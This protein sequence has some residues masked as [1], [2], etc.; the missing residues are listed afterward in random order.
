MMAGIGVALGRDSRTFTGGLLVNAIAGVACQP[1]PGR[2]PQSRPLDI[3]GALLSTSALILAII[4]GPNW[5]SPRLLAVVLGLG[6][7]IRERHAPYPL[8]DFALFR[9]PRFSTG[10]ATISLAFFSGFIFGFTQYLQ[11]VQGYRLAAGIRFLPIAAGFMF[12]AKAMKQLRHHQS[13]GL[14]T[15]MTGMPLVLLWET[16]TSYLVVGPIVAVFALGVGFGAAK[17]GVGSAMN[18]VTQMLASALRPWSD[19]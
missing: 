12:G 17:A 19:Q 9:L 15:I 7:V 8:L 14:L 5:G 3:P 1:I 16:D 18:D 4:E 2:D 10:A 6:F 11:F 13:C